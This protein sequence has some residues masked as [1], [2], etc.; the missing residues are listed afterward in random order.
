MNTPTRPQFDTKLPQFGTSEDL[1][2]FLRAPLIQKLYPQLLGGPFFTS[3]PCG[4][5]GMGKD[6]AFI[7]NEVF[8]EACKKVEKYDHAR[9]ESRL[10]SVQAAPLLQRVGVSRLRRF[11]EKRVEECYRRNVAKIVPLLQGELRSAE[12]K[13]DQTNQELEALSM[14]F[15]KKT[16][17]Q[18]REFFLRSLGSVIQG[19]C[20]VPR[21][22]GAC[23]AC[24]RA[25]WLSRTPP[26][27]IPHDTPHP[28]PHPTQARSR[29]PPRSTARRW[30]R[31]SCG[32]GRSWTPRTCRR[33]AGSG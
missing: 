27:P 32:V 3:V 23:G 9:V 31:S 19:A 26:S 29:R 15:L 11:L 16:A 30:R 14:D 20:R 33:S 25:G 10:G 2:D 5:V 6:S 22:C 21:G 7:S 18:F 24:W 1:E 28:A 8:V 4:R 13:L 17:N 12:M